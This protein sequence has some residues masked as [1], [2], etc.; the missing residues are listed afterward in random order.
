M[1]DG[2]RVDLLLLGI[3]PVAELGSLITH[4]PAD[5]RIR[6][7]LAVRQARPRLFEPVAMDPDA[8]LEEREQHREHRHVAQHEHQ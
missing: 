2:E 4:F 1:P 5:V 7:R 8:D 3:Q 6:H